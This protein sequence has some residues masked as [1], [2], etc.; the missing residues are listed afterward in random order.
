LAAKSAPKKI[1]QQSKRQAVGKRNE[2]TGLNAR[3]KECHQGCR[4]IYK[5]AKRRLGKRLL[6]HKDIAAQLK[7]LSIRTTLQERFLD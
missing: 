6:K 4:R 5:A 3:N 7:G 1:Y 2:R